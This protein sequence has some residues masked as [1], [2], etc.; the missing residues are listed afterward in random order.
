MMIYHKLPFL[1]HGHVPVEFIIAFGKSGKFVS[2]QCKDLTTE[3]IAYGL[4]L[5]IDNE[6]LWQERIAPYENL[7]LIN[8]PIEL[9]Q[10]VDKLFKLKVFW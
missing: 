4:T 6:I 10:Y 9:R 1:L 8:Y 7:S 5:F 2:V 3:K